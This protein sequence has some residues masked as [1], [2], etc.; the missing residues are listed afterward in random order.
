MSTTDE[1]TQ[2]SILQQVEFYFSES[3][4]LNDRFLFTTQNAN[5]GWVPIQTI[6]QFERMK[7]YRPI[8]VIVEALR[9]SP[10]LLEVSE[11]GEM[12]RRKIAL[13]KNYNEIQLNIN[14]RSIFVEKLPETATLD[15]LLKFFRSIAPTNQVR[16]KKNREKKFTGSCIVEFK[17]A[18]DAEKILADITENKLKYGEGDAAVELDV[19][20]K[21]S[22]D[23]SKAQKF[24]E[25]R[26]NKGNKN[27]K[28]G[29]KE[30]SKDEE[31]KE[32]AEAKD[33]K[34]RDASPVRKAEEVD[35]KERD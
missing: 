19:I 14:K 31:S 33:S 22:Y 24:G 28:R 8:E 25:R 5:D 16:M 32:S 20:S 30:D 6:S 27:K 4:L 15:D 12:V 17:D 1:Q 3:N 13:P 29:R 34:E 21:T 9:K 18:K 2:Q 11:N 23:E 35:V 10:E 26:G 7:K